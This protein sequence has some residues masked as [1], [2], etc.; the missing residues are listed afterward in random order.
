MFK[1]NY[2]IKCIY[3]S[4][5]DSHDCEFIKEGIKKGI[6]RSFSD[7]LGP[8]AYAFRDKEIEELTKEFSLR[9]E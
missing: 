5:H 7:T 3:N 6:I 9:N 8:T 2:S 4:V 1:C